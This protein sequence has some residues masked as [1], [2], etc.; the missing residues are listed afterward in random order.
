M[1]RQLE[2]KIKDLL[3]EGQFETPAGLPLEQVVNKIKDKTL[4]FFDTETTTLF[5][6]KKYAQI[7]EI[8]A[9]AYNT[10][11]GER[12]GEYNAKARL[13]T[14]ALERIEH[15]KAAQAA[16][17]WPKGKPTIEDLFAMTSYYEKS[18]PFLEE[19]DMMIEFVDFINGFKEQQPMLVAH[20]AV[21]DLYTIGKALERHR[22]P[23]MNRYPVLDTINLTRKY[24][25]PILTAL[26]DSEDP[27]V[28]NLIA[29]LK[30]GLKYLNR[31]G[32]LGTAFEISTKHW[33][34]AIA[35]TEQLAGILS[36]IIQFIEKHQATEFPDPRIR[37]LSYRTPEYEA[38]KAAKAA[39]AAGTIAEALRQ[40][41]LRLF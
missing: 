30:P 16:G 28:K 6:I 10:S 26:K 38:Y 7:T 12:L 29:V 2:R 36:A 23:R 4:I 27:E 37:D 18:A 8:A 40:R 34:S 22:L 19:K 17:T 25:F 1:K 9:V 39:A 15:E 21:F 35:D 20:N 32:N 11:T 24:L 13:S 33:H 31:L 41:R 14:A 5:P 3:T